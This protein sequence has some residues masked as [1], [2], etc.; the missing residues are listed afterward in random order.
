MEKFQT[1]D[2]VN[3]IVYASGVRSIILKYEKPDDSFKT[4]DEE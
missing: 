2:E 4:E 3:L 1:N